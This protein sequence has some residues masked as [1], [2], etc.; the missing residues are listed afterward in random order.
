MQLEVSKPLKTVR[1]NSR[2]L[3]LPT[4]QENNSFFLAVVQILMNFWDT[5]RRLH[6]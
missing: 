5:D 2:E 1:H 4:M 6:L 3:R